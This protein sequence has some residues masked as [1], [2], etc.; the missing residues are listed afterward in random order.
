MSEI[1]ERAA[2][3]HQVPEPGVEVHRG[4]G[5]D[6]VSGPRKPALDRVFKPMGYSCKGESGAFTLR[7][8]TAGN[9]TAELHLDIGAWGHSVAAIFRVFGVG[10]KGTVLLPYPR[11]R[12]SARNAQS[13]MRSGGRRSSRT[14]RLWWRIWIG[15]LFLRSR[16]RWVR[17]RNGISPKVDSG[18]RVS[19]AHQLSFRNH[20]D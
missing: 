8:R 2:L 9:L 11:T 15:A 1:V 5:L 7:R 20:P 17:R 10:F 4:A 3:P 13:G 6:V 12:L 19:A 16:R 14:W 18:P